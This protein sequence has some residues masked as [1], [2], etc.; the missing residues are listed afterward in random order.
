MYNIVVG[1]GTTVGGGHSPLQRSF[2][3][4]HIHIIMGGGGQYCSGGGGQYCSGGML[5]WGTSIMGGG[6]N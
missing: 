1:G 5:N 3:N 2:L 6:G 4:I